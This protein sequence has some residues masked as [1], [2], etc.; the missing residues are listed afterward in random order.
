[1]SKLQRRVSEFLSANFGSYDIRENY[2]ADWLNTPDGSRLQL[3]FY[4]SELNL[5]IE[6]QGPQHFNFI[7]FFH[8]DADGFERRQ[9]F[10]AFKRE[11]CEFRGVQLV[12]VCDEADVLNLIILKPE[13]APALF[14]PDKRTDAYRMYVKHEKKAYEERL[15]QQAVEKK[16]GLP[17]KGPLKPEQV[18]ELKQRLGIE[19]DLPADDWS[20]EM[21]ALAR[22]IKAR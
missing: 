6:V 10:D 1:M 4:L 15:H 18:A 8:K 13:I 5:A 19:G 14:V 17:Q 9:T 7:E 22:E 16:K 2:N 11:A 21:K 20:P 3:D 12:E